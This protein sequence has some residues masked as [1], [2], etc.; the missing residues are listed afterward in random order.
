M[1]M[2]VNVVPKMMAGLPQPT[3]DFPS[4][5]LSDLAEAQRDLKGLRA[6]ESSCLPTLDVT[7]GKTTKDSKDERPAD[8]ADS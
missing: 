7:N 4:V 8:E 1:M 2:P 5:P 6:P 3:M